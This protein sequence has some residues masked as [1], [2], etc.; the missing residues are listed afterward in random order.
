MAQ[1]SWLQRGTI[2]ENIVWGEIYD[3]NRYKKVLYACALYEDIRTIDENCTGVGEGGG[4]LSG[5]QR[6]RVA[7]ARAVYQNK[8][9]NV[10]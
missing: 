10:R 9:S 3:E 2:R 4:T 5:G 7:L 1:S 6:V 8:Q